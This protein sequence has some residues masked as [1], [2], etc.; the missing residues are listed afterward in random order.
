MKMEPILFTIFVLVGILSLFPN[1][2]IQSVK[3]R[4]VIETTEIPIKP[5][6][7]YENWA[8]NVLEDTQS[9]S[10]QALIFSIP[11]LICFIWYVVWTTNPLVYSSWPPFIIAILAL[12]AAVI[13]FRVTLI[14]WIN[15]KKNIILIEKNER[16]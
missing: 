8:Y 11:I 4:R 9:N 15:Q 2:I 13:L 14:H 7:W 1:I 12:H 16:P 3:I 6:T 5:K 10:Y